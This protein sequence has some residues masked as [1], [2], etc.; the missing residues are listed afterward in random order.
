MFQEIIIYLTLSLLAIIPWM[1][2]I[3]VIH[4]NNINKL[5]EI[6]L[7]SNIKQ[8]QSNSILLSYSIKDDI[9]WNIYTNKNLSVLEI[10]NI[11][12]IQDKIEERVLNWWNIESYIFYMKNINWVIR[13]FLIEILNNSSTKAFNYSIYDNTEG[14]FIEHRYLINMNVKYL[15]DDSFPWKFVLNN[16]DL[17][18]YLFFP[19]FNKK[20]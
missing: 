8:S 15:W 3:G 18:I 1:I 12:Q 10:D 16:K 19:S 17:N 4:Q 13:Y 5:E 11:K 9:T 2:W 7:I 20:F 14:N 6:Y